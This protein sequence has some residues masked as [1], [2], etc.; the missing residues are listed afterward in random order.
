MGDDLKVMSLVFDG[1]F[2]QN[3]ALHMV[4]QLG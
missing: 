3:D 2:G 1:A 4:K